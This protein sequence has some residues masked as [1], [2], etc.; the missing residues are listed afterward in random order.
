MI[1]EISDVRR[2]VRALRVPRGLLFH[3][4]LR[5]RLFSTP[6]DLA[7]GKLRGFLEKNGLHADAPAPKQ[8]P[9]LRQLFWVR[10]ED[11]PSREVRTR[12]GARFACACCG[13]S[14]QTMKLGPLLPADVERLRRADWNGTGRDRSTFFV[15]EHDQPLGEYSDAFLRREGSRCQFLRDDN[16][17]E[18]HA[19]FGAMTKPLMCRMFPYVFRATP[20]AVAVG[21][22]LGECASAPAAAKGLPVVEQHDDL[23]RMLSEHDAIGL[24]PPSVWA[25]P[26]RLIT[27]EEYER[28]ESDLLAR[29]VG[30][31]AAAVFRAFE[32]APSPKPGLDDLVA[33][34]GLPNRPPR[35]LDPEAAE[36]EDRF[37]RAVLFSKELFLH[38]DLA[39]AAALL[40][41]KA[42]LARIEVADGSPA[43][44][45]QVWKTSADRPLRDLCR[46]LDVRG[47]AAS[48]AAS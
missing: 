11:L 43:A 6:A 4:P 29:P 3:D 9:R 24:V 40:V 12:P 23:R 22:R 41:I 32:T 7:E 16:L 13:Q 10:V 8:Q 31:F 33:K 30:G 42:H 47:I 1:E 5:W 44:I 39:R 36:L 35:K 38:Q 26:D 15:D 37:C 21:M 34:I 14:C 46:D 2:G 20:A 45:N 18:V 48:I 27:W 28:I 25:S 19:R 17:C